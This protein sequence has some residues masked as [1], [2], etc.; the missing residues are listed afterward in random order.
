ML[1]VFPADGRHSFWMKDMLFSIDMLWLD[2]N[3]RVVHVEKGVSPATFPQ[4]FTPSSPSRYVLEVPS[5]FCDAHG[6]EVGDMAI[7]P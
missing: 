2:A 4:T 1:F 7:F 3:G 5:G 6:I